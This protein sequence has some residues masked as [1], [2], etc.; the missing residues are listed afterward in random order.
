MEYAKTLHKNYII[1][2]LSN[3]DGA[4]F[5]Y[6]ARNKDFSV[7]E[8]R[9]LSFLIGARKPNKKIY[10]YAIKKLNVRPGEILFIDDVKKNV[11]GAKKAGI[12]AI[13]FKNLN[14]LKRR[15]SKLLV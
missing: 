15:A 11:E 7:F 13:Q 3:T 5:N 14:D 9:F 8:Y 10:Q 2:C 6:N 1:G 4:S 12:K